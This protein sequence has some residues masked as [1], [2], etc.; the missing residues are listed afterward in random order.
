MHVLVVPSWY[1]TTEAPLDG[2]YFAEQ[3]QCLAERD[4]QVGIVYPEQQS[5][6]RLSVSA[7]QTKH[8]Q[9]EWTDD[10][11]LP[12]LR[13]YGWNLWWRFPPGLRCRV[14]S[15][16]RLAHRYVDRY[17]V[18]DL[19]HAQSGHWAGAAAARISAAFSMPYVLTEHFSG[20]WRNGIFPW[21]WPL[22]EEGYR[23]ANG[24]AAVSTPLRRTLVAQDLGSLSNIE[25]HPNLAP[26]SHFTRPPSG[27]PSP[28]P[29]RFVT[30]TRLTRQKNITTLLHAFAR[31]AAE[32]DDTALSIVGDGPERSSLE[33][34]T[35][36]LGLDDRVTFRGRLDRDSVRSALWNAHAFVLPS[37]HE[38]FGVVLL[39]AM[40]TGL[41]VVATR[42]GGPEDLVTP[43]T[44]FLVP[45]ADTAALADALRSMRERW[46]SFNPSDIRS[47]TV[48]HYGPEPFARRTRLLYRRA[49]DKKG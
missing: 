35:R 39:E 4:F 24:I 28:P 49:L 25:V 9:T 19:V 48:E 46:M 17:G 13:R 27:R 22:V 31:V 37:Q 33:R 15:A 44:G 10:H 1:P 26:T 21:R 18:P 6:R 47:H 7:L 29:F 12:T 3:A 23:H 36:W 11:D 32:E 30:I 43:D 8:F 41:P 42:C 2:I 34:K 38:T 14:R 16:V 20:F 45:V 40:A 5:L